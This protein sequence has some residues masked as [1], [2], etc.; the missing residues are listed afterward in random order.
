MGS[1]GI[2]QNTLSSGV[3]EESNDPVPPDPRNEHVLVDD[4]SENEQSSEDMVPE[5]AVEDSCNQSQQSEMQGVAI[6]AG[7]SQQIV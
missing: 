6:E 5:T 4:E 7:L 2:Y 1:K 3:R